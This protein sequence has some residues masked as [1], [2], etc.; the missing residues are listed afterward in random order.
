MAARCPGFPALTHSLCF[1]CRFQNL[2][3]DRAGAGVPVFQEKRRGG[4]TNAGLPASR[5][6]GNP[7]APSPPAAPEEGC[8]LLFLHPGHRGTG[9]ALTYLSWTQVLA[10]RAGRPAALPS[11]ALP[12]TP[13]GSSSQT[14]GWHVLATGKTGEEGDFE[15][16]QAFLLPWTG[17]LC[18]STSSS[19]RM[20][21]PRAS[22]TGLVSACAF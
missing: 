3:E 6:G 19:V 20:T 11:L 1:L 8:R 15:S 2:R 10:P 22:A 4:P 17:T 16:P 18:T 14:L 21:L 13:A 12:C 5:K 7:Q 9:S